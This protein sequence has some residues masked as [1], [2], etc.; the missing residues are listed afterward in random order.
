VA[1]SRVGLFGKIDAA[2]VL[3]KVQQGFAETIPGPVSAFTRQTMYNASMMLNVQ[4]GI[5]WTPRDNWRISAGY[6]YEHW[7]DAAFANA[8]RG[9]VATQGIFFRGEWKF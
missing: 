1:E 7:W 3:G 6:T 4:A 5:G 8:S 2:G 9:D